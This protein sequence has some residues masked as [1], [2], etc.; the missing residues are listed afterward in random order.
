MDQ[1][2][3]DLHIHSRF[4]RAT[5][6]KLSPRNLSAWAKVKGLDVM[7]TGDFTHPGWLAELE[8]E[9][10]LDPS[11]L[12]VLKDS[13]HLETEIPEFEGPLPP[14]TTRFI[15]SAEISSIY[16]RGGK[17]RKVHN[18]VFM[19]S[20]DRVKAFN[21]KL[22]EVGNLASDGRPIL[23]LDSRHL[24][25]IV[26]ETDPLAFLVPA[27]IW[28]PWF[29]L[30]GSKSGFDSIEECFGDLSGE[31][32][33]LETGL[34]SDPAMNWLWSKLDRFRFISNSDAHSGEN[35]GREANLFSGEPSFEGIYRS[36]RGEGLGHKFLGTLEFFPE[37][38]KYHL[39]GHR[40][41]NVV[42][43]PRET[44]ARGGMCPVCGKPVTVGVLNRVLTLSDRDTPKKPIHHP[45][46]SSIIP[47]P[48]ILS[49]ILNSGPKTKT[50]QG[51][52]GKLIRRFGSEMT[53]LL[54]TPVEELTTWSA[55]LGEA[56]DRMRAGKVHRR[57]GFDGE[58]GWIS[59]F[60]PKELKEMH[61]GKTLI[62]IPEGADTGHV[63]S[64]VRPM[65][66]EPI[67][68]QTLAFIPNLEQEKAAKAGPGPILVIAGPGTGKTRT[69]VARVQYL[70]D[71][72][73]NPEQI[74]TVTFTRRA[75]QELK[76]RLRSLLGK[77][78]LL[79]KADTLHALG[80]E[81]WAETHGQQPTLMAAGDEERCFVSANPEL[82]R[83]QAKTLWT[84]MSL[85]REERRSI[86][87]AV[88]RAAE[89]YA[90]L[91]AQ[92]NLV[93]YTD[94]LEF[95][96][97]QIESTA[98]IRPYS[99]LLV[100]EVQDLTPLQLSLLKALNQPSGNGF[101]AIGDTR[102]AI[103]GF[104]GAVVNIQADLSQRWPE[105]SVITLDRNYRSIQPIL[106]VAASLFSGTLPL[107][108]ERSGQGDISLFSA[109][110]TAHEASWIAEKIRD[111]VGGTGHWQA[112]TSQ[113]SLSPGEIG[114]LVR[115]KA[116]MPPIF[117]ALTRFGLPAS[118]PENEAFW[119]EPRVEI[120]LASVGRMLGL[121]EK[122]DVAIISCPDRILALGPSGLAAYLKD[123]P[124]FDALFWQSSAYH[125]LRKLYDQ[126]G[127][128]MNL[129]NFIHLQSELEMVR[130][131]AEKI[132][133]MTL[134]AAK[135]LE[136]SAVF[137]PALEDGILPFA[138]KE[139]FSEH[140]FAP[141]MPMDEEE[142]KRLFYVGMTRARDLLFLS[143]VEKRR[144][145]G[146]NLHLPPSRFL[147]LLPEESIK[148]STMKA[149]K[150]TKEK[151][152][153][154]L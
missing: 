105:L 15:F 29:S 145:Y 72:G 84:E 126:S 143:L 63:H 50:V 47:L 74:V 69:L 79:P 134:H 16:K 86:P 116:L 102:Q 129:I 77:Q 120:I 65:S 9:L 43:D 103:Y 22:A 36:L 93:D 104:R 96:I 4:S 40:K 45:D 30:F 117:E 94:L 12:L 92:W 144:L 10:Q 11:G 35:L 112:D 147:S 41:C 109:P 1:F 28:T 32:F 33:A 98:F 149:Q 153:R 140:G 75:A 132:Q 62:A 59:V 31:I 67:Q 82:D 57:S 48:E 56:I 37:E 107:V 91:K 5:S 13:T 128:W 66:P 130:A 87:E 54:K 101:F 23:G 70:L 52:Y 131:K 141:D 135:G 18:L 38:G 113:G 64:P 26:R 51:Y 121:T 151:Q 83:S 68:D 17:V 100:D 58:F 137:L 124:P 97:E 85:A 139:L 27:H 110:S 122:E 39:D 53:V 76:T 71:S 80:F 95:F 99:H 118:M 73:V 3:A 60:S 49:D 34:S 20:F 81:Y 14:G 114:I 125:S 42:L 19:P 138:G 8:T 44:L 111:L 78:T 2:R 146:R 115:F 88:N 152:L 61:G 123:M 24:L 25:E 46:F 108:A 150:V 136:F 7:G 55:P 21:R 89:N 133:I 106:D 154:F 142:E 6:K 127:G 90:Q 148:K 119:L